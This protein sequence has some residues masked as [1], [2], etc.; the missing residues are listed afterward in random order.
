MWIRLPTA[1]P[2]KPNP[3]AH[4]TSKIIIIVQSIKFL[5]FPVYLLVCFEPFET[6][7]PVVLVRGFEAA[8][9]VVPVETRSVNFLPA[10]T[11]P[12]TAPAAAPLATVANAPVN[13]S[14]ALASIVFADVLFVVFEPFPDVEDLAVDAEAFFVPDGFEVFFAAVVFVL[15]ADAFFAPEELLFAESVD[16]AVVFFLFVAILFVANKRSD[17]RTCPLTPVYKFD[18]I[19]PPNAVNAR[20]MPNTYTSTGG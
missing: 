2:A 20:N 10:T 3:N 18:T 14:V 13:A 9:F 4:S 5:L 8:F 11:A 16:F 12:A 19:L 7:F 6:P 17:Q 1:A 15:A